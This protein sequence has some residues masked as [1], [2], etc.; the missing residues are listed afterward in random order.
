MK[1]IAKKRFKT[2]VDF[3]FTA[4]RKHKIYKSILKIHVT[5]RILIFIVC[6]IRFTVATLIFP[7]LPFGNFIL[8]LWLVVLFPIDKVK[9][10]FYYI[11]NKT[12]LKWFYTKWLQWVQ[13]FRK[14]N[15]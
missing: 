7:P 8:I 11:V 12:R 2:M 4:V 9:S 13:K 6:L 15:N 1:N 10:K 5:F 14:K 3:L